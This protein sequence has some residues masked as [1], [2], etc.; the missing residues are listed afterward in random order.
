MQNK[1]L[2]SD[3]WNAL[4]GHNGTRFMYTLSVFVD[5]DMKDGTAK[6]RCIPI[7]WTWGSEREARESVSR[8]KAAWESNAF[9]IQEEKGIMTALFLAAL[10]LG[11][12]EKRSH[13]DTLRRDFAFDHA[14]AA[15][16]VPLH[17]D[18]TGGDASYLLFLGKKSLS[19]GINILEGNNYNDFAKVKR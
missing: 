10:P 15:A 12:I 6:V 14:L 8:M 5:K 17:A 18:F 13:I 7:M 19:T 11:L 9:I 1:T 16:C 4:S 3:I 2:F